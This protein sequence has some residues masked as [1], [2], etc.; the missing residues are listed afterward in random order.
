VGIEATVLDPELDRVYL[1][2]VI[3]E[4]EA[5][6]PPD[7]QALARGVRGASMADVTRV[8]R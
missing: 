5:N 3:D 8:R 6:L 7:L 1:R 4:L 2:E